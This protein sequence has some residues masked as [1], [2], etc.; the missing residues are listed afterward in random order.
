[1][2]FPI[3]RQP[4]TSTS[5]QL[6]AQ[7][8]ATTSEKRQSPA[9][10]TLPSNGTSV[11]TAG[12]FPPSTDTHSRTDPARITITESAKNAAT[13]ASTRSFQIIRDASAALFTPGGS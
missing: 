9:T 1:M 8:A 2:V 4:P 7:Q 13:P 3:Q 6:P 11:E 10:A 5:N 12:F